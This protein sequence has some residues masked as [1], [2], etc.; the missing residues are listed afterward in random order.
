MPPV[1]FVP[2]TVKV[3]GAEAVP[4]VLVKGPDKGPLLIVGEVLAT[5]PDI[6]SQAPL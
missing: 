4:Y 6:A 3:T 2:E 1:I 5:P